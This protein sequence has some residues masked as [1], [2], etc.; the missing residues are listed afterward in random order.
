MYPPTHPNFSDGH[1]SQYPSPS[2]TYGHC[3]QL[4]LEF[5]AQQ[6]EDWTVPSVPQEAQ[7]HHLGCRKNHWNPIHGHVRN[8]NWRYLP[9]ISR[10]KAYVREYPH[11]IWPYM[12]Q[13]LHFRMLNFPLILEVSM[14]S[15][16][17]DMSNLKAPLQMDTSIKPSQAEVLWLTHITWTDIP[18]TDKAYSCLILYI[19]FYCTIPIVLSHIMVS[20]VANGSTFSKRNCSNL[21]PEMSDSKL[22]CWYGLAGSKAVGIRLKSGCKTHCRQLCIILAN[23][24]DHIC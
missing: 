23:L 20:L 9:D 1:W 11:K 12:V 8:L 22:G 21:C 15:D 13:Y 4:D 16:A 5:R 10:Y 18:T 3:R 24:C 17:V 6:A 7:G 14:F 19:N 2:A